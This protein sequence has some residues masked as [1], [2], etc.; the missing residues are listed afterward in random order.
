MPFCSFS[1]GAAMFDVTPIE[2]MFLLEYLPTAPEGFLRVYLYARMLCLHPELG[3]EIADVAKALRMDEDAVFNAFAYWEKQGLVERLTDRPPSYA[4]RPIRGGDMQSEMDRDYYAYR[5]FNASMQDLFGAEHL[6]QPNQYKL[7]NDWLNVLGMSQEAVL[8]LLEYELKHG[9]KQPASVFKRADK[10]AAEWADRGIRTL[11]DVEK[12]I[13]YDDRVYSMA[14]MVMKQFSLRRHA[15]VNELDCVRRWIGEWKLTEQ[16]VLDACAQ[17]TKSRSPT[18]G[19][20]DAILRERAQTGGDDS[21]E[22]TKDVLR[23]L[24]APQ[25]V[26]TPEQVK[27][28]RAWL[29]Q[30][31]E[32]EALQLAAKRCAGKGWHKFESLE[33]MLEQWA[34]EGVYSHAAAEAYLARMRQ[35]YL[36]ALNVMQAAGLSRRPG[37]EDMKRCEAWKA[38]FA[39]E[40]ILFAAE[41]AR[42]MGKPMLYMEKVLASWEREGVST[43]EG[44]REA[45]ERATAASKAKDAPRQQAAPS[46]FQ[47]RSYT[48]QETDK[49]YFDLEKFFS[50]EG[51]KV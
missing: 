15:T 3:G 9:G 14:N 37:A 50:E 44:A 19:Y 51:D 43:L 21:F 2:N 38:R 23:E 42:G 46:N 16:D 8:K 25:A 35:S 12:A 18:I 20:L 41:C 13:A 11:E 33:D 47:Q 45:R 40:I 39:P 26:P 24:G 6:L 34:A 1:D 29:D 31:F 27:K 10:R 4:I 22:R 17:T 28:Y 49:D 48:K 5:D 30:G 7:A 36:E 32:V